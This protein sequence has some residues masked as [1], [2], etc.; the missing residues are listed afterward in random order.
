[1][2]HQIATSHHKTSFNSRLRQ[3]G[4]GMTEYI[5]IVGV[6]AIAAIGIFGMFGKTVKQQITGMAQELA[7]GD[8]SSIQQQADT[9]SKAAEAKANQANDLSNYHDND[10]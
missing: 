7:G 6:I 5:I 1:M 3:R 8:G 9:E 10:G 4:Q 2:Q